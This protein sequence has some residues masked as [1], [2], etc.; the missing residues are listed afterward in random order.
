MAKFKRFTALV[1]ALCLICCMTVFASADSTIDQSKTGSL[2]L[3]KYDLT[4]A[5]ADGAWDSSAYVST[6]ESDQGVI[7]ALAG[8]AVPGV[9]FTYIKVARNAGKQRGSLPERTTPPTS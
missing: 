7:D 1:L 4:S 2:T 5:E 9:E 3:Y 8:Y 6:G